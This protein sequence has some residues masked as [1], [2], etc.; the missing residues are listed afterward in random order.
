MTGVM[1][2]TWRPV[3]AGTLIAALLVVG[4]AA[5]GD[6][7]ESTGG[8]AAAGEVTQGSQQQ[9]GS[10]AVDPNSPSAA[11]EVPGG[12]NSVQRFGAEASGAERR[13]A[14]VLVGGYMKAVAADDFAAQCGYLSRDSVEPLERVTDP[15]SEEGGCAQALAQLRASTPGS[16]F[17]AM[18]GPVGS[19]RVEGNQGFAL[20][21]GKNGTDYVL[22]L[23]REGGVWRVASLVPVEI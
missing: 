3:L 17:G 12:D 11:F 6:G 15:E 1:G 9:G 5:C 16:T 22:P 13:Q 14:S 19:L 7:E 20:Y 21:H 8:A 18:A 2:G 10:T 4:L 23:K